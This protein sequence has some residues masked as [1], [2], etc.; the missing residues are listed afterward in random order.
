VEEEKN[1]RGQ[2]REGKKGGV[3]VGD[4]GGG[5]GGGILGGGKEKGGGGG[6]EV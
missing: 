4:G 5:G 6:S 1:I 3:C 2:S